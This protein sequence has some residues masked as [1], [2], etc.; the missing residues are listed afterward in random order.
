MLDALGLGWCDEVAHYREAAGLQDV[1]TPSYHQVAAPVHR[2]AA[3]RWKRHEALL[4]PHLAAL[5]PWE[6][7]VR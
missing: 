7:P 5:A 1:K 3:G 2:R 6:E 4:A